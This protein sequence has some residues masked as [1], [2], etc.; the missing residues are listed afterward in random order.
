MQGWAPVMV[1]P[2]GWMGMYGQPPFLQPAPHMHPP[3]EMGED[4]FE[5]MPPFAT[6]FND[7]SGALLVPVE[8]TFFFDY[9]C[10]LTPC[11][12]CQW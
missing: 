4:T 9:P 7:D 8:A 1:P 6:P 3:Q 11:S 5:Q 12:N 2:P 10:I